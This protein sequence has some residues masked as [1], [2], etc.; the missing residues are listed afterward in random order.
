MK[1]TPHNLFMSALYGGRKGARPPAGNP[2]SIACRE[3]MKACGAG[4]P[5]AHLN[6]RAMADLALAGHELA[7]FD[8]VMPEY[9]VHQE[10]AALGCEVDW[11]NETRMPD[12]RTTPHA[13]FSDV[14]VPESILDKPSL[15]VVLDALSIL[16]REVGGQAAIIGKVMGPWTLAYHVAGTQNFL[17]RLGLGEADRIHRMLRQ[18]MPVT[19]RFANAQLKAGADAVVLADHATGSL[20]GPYHYRDFLL[21]IHREI[22]ARVGGPMILHV[23][24]NCL[25]RLELFAESGVDAYHFEWQVDARAAVEKIGHRISLIGNVNNTRTLLQGTPEDVYG[26]ARYAIA[27]GVHIIGPEC[28]I[29]LTTPLANIRA[30]AAAVREGY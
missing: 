2:T 26:Q 22:T 9:S 23:C 8:T 17:L 4:F 18:L 29:P 20:V 3:L 5:E 13:D 15:R 1:P 24:G 27:A 21:P 16:R 12:A 7:G 19:I 28:A 11:G 25:D 30:I 10:S 6:P 14:V